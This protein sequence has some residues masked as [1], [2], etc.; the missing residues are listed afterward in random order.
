MTGG[1]FLATAL[2]AVSTGMALRTVADGEKGVVSVEL[3]K[4][5]IEACKKESCALL[6]DTQL[7]ELISAAMA[8]GKEEVERRLDSNGC[9]AGKL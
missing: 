5:T 7:N 6:T 1:F 2:L 3:P 4:A 9:L 8:V